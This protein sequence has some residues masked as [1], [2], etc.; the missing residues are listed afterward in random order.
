[1]PTV[2]CSCSATPPTAP[3]TAIF[4]GSTNPE[5]SEPLFISAVAVA[6][7]IQDD[8]VFKLVSNLWR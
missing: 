7:G 4:Q 3:F 6:A 8:L 5:T 2:S 1:M